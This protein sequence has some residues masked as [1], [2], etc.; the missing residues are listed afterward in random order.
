MNP[1]IW[2]LCLAI[3]LMALAFVLF[4]PETVYQGL[5]RSLF[6][7]SG[8]AFSYQG[9]L[10]VD[11]GLANGPFDFNFALYDA[12]A[13]GNQ[14]GITIP[15]DDVAVSDGKF[16]VL[17]DFGDVFD[18]SSLWLQIGVSPDRDTIPISTLSPRQLLSSTP[19]ASYAS[20][21]P[22]SGLAGVPGDLADG[23]D[24]VLGGLPCGEGQVAKRSG[25]SWICGHQ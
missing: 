2:F 4:P 20:K 16:T 9:Y 8:T 18:G 25:G 19:Y 12:V 14:V 22:W 23:D 7:T 13:A 21:S 6:N 10:T 3:L 17:L 15:E 5:E 11:E 1:T 24:D